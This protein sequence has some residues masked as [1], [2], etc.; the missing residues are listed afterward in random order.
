MFIDGTVCWSKTAFICG[1]LVC[2][3]VRVRCIS[4]SIVAIVSKQSS[5]FTFDLR[6]D[7]HLLSHFKV[8][9]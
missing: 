5:Q 9:G 7:P 4:G 1:R 6:V 8:Y 3:R 2:E